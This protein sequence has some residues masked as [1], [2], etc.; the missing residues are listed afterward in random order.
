MFILEFLPDNIIIAIVGG[1]IAIGIVGLIIDYIIY[2][3]PFLLP[4]RFII[5]FISTIILLVGVYF[6]GAYVTELVWK[7]RVAEVQ[8]RVAIAE[9]KSHEVNTIIQEKVVQKI[10][11]VEK[12]VIVNHNIIEKHKEIINAECKIPD[13]AFKIYNISALGGAYE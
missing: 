13:I 12:K 3:I 5:K 9:A 8:M 10:K 6:A 11:V 1:C 7:E 4:F 2:R